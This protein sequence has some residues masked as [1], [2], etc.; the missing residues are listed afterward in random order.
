VDRPPTLS[1]REC[2]RELVA[3]GAVEVR[4]DPQQW[5]VWAS[6][7]RA[8]IYCDNRLLISFP[9][10]RARI[11]D[12]LAEAIRRGLPGAEV[13]AGTATAGIPHAAWVAERLELPMVYVRAS[14]KDHGRARRVE[15]RPLRGERVVLV[16]DLISTGASALAAVEALRAEGG[17]VLGVQAIFTYGLSDAER[18]FEAA[19][20]RVQALTSFAALLETLDLD[21][22]SRRAL[23]A[24]R[25]A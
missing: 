21:D 11:A 10:L 17:Q 14:A 7:R 18:A 22:A 5:F 1:A 4:A 8:P 13:V 19:G 6:G 20:V 24:W 16:E 25:N 3:I 2:A 12:A 23:L 15:G 9:K